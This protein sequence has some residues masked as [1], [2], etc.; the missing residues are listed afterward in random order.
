MRSILS[1][2]DDGRSDWK[3]SKKGVKGGYV[4]TYIPYRKT[5]SKLQQ[6]APTMM[7][8]NLAHIE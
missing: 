6:F 3:S 1:V 8:S 7:F 5:L 2:F 4:D